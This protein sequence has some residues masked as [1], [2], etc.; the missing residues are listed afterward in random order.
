MDIDF[1]LALKYL[2]DNLNSDFINNFIVFN[3]N[4]IFK[5]IINNKNYYVLKYNINKKV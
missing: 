3:I 4:N 1:K 5:E 2:I